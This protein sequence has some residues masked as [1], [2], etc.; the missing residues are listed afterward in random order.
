MKPII[1]NNQ[2]L[3][4]D[5]LET[6][7]ISA[8]SSSATTLTVKN[9]SGFTTKQILLIGELGS[10]NSEIIKTHAAT[11]PSDTTITLASSIS[12]GHQLATKVKVVPYDQ[13]EISYSATATGS[14]TVLDTVELTTDSIHTRYE[15]QDYSSG[16][17][18]IRFKNTALDPNIYSDYSDPIPYEGYDANNVGSIIAYA[19]KRNKLETFT[20]FV[21]YDFCIEEINSCMKYITG[22]LKK[23]TRLQEFDYNLGTLTRGNYSLAIPDNV[24]KH[25]Y[26]SVLDARVEG[27][28]ALIYKDKKEFND[29]FEG[30]SLKT[31]TSADTGDITFELD[32]TTNLD[33]DGTVM[34]N[35]NLITYTA[36][37]GNTLTGIPASG[38]GSITETITAGDNVW[39]GSYNE[40]TP[41]YFTVYDEYMYFYPLTSSS[42]A[43][44]RIS[45]DFWKEAPEID[46]DNDEIDMYRYDMIKHW[47]TW[48]IRMQL[49][50]D[51][52]RNLNDG[53]YMQFEVILRDAIK[54][55]ITGQKYKTK[56]KLNTINYEN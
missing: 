22:K 32:N 46:S 20:Q 27:K 3:T 34:V 10:E 19:L 41:I 17:Y 26:K 6:Y 45:V 40:G 5:A 31:A 49:K 29:L 23:W 35:G 48:S 37:S 43:S 39:Q 8:A 14:K 56:P 11:S 52:I 53:D 13:V 25:S 18:F 55:E 38:T 16:Y 24:W 21:D 42:T 7:L 12:Q 36:I 1:I 2:I 54:G 44:R 33:D 28:E 4:T 50:N 51:G 47:L 30:I 9:I 15:D